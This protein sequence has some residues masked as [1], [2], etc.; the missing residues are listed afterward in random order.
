MKALLAVFPLDKLPDAMK[1]QVFARVQLEAQRAAARVDRP[2]EVARLRADLGRAQA[3]R[4]EALDLRHEALKAQHACEREA[5]AAAH[6]AQDKGVLTARLRAQPKGMVA[7]LV[8][9]TGIKLLIEQRHKR[10][11]RD[12]ATDQQKQRA[13][14]GR[15]HDRELVDFSRHYRALGSLDKREARSLETALRHEEF[16]AIAQPRAMEARL[17]RPADAGAGAALTPDQR[18]RLEAI[19]QAG[20]AP[21][22]VAKPKRARSPRLSASF[23]KAARRPSIREVFADAASPR[24]PGRPRKPEPTPT[25]SEPSRAEEPAPSVRSTFNDAAGGRTEPERPP[26]RPSPPPEPRR[27]RSNRDHDRER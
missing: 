18:A 17:R 14:L 15:R 19:R 20:F 3:Q 4:R 16:R 8:R 12:R 9:I 23:E 1:A 25:A 21:E 7:F 10:Q 13:A 2:A 5:L 27:H 26:E 22:P 6:E 24:R 11:D